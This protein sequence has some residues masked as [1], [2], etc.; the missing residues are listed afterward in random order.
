MLLS[1][2]K[3]SYLALVI[4]AALAIAPA[5]SATTLNISFDGTVVGTATLTQGGTCD[6]QT[7]A[8]T[9]V[10]VD[11]QMKSGTQIRMSGN[12]VI[13]LSGNLNVAGNPT[14]IEFDSSGLLTLK[15]GACAG[16]HSLICLGAPANGGTNLS[17]LFFALTNADL[18][19]GITINEIHIIG[20]VCGSEQTCHAT[21][22]AVPE[23]GT[24][25]LLGTGL[26]GIA[27]LVRRRFTK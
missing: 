8:T 15:S 25:G 14:A 11:I 10:C 9:S 23:P 17:S 1:S 4:V 18:S 12:G 6:S 22:S 2:L 3:P 21:T 19:T 24:L 5:A 16:T 27:G 7:I 20:A 26:I 13:G